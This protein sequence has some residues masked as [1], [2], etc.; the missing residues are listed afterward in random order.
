ML[1]VLCKVVK[2]DRDEPARYDVLADTPSPIT[3]ELPLPSGPYCAGC[4]PTTVTGA[5]EA[6]TGG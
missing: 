5:T 3:G 4:W 6:S 2:I 1:C